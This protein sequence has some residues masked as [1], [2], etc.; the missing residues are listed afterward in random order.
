MD[1]DWLAAIVERMR[2][3]GREAL[4]EPEG[5]QILEAL[6]IATPK[7]VLVESAPQA[8]EIDLSRFPGDRVVVKAVSAGLTHKSEAG[9][10][11]VT[12]KDRRLISDAIRAMTGRLGDLDLRGYLV[13]EFVAYDPAPGGE[14]LL[15]AR[16]T[17]DFGPVVTCGPGGI[18]AELLSDS[19]KPDAGL[20]IASPF[21]LD[22]GAAAEILKDITVARL[23]TE[24]LR[25]QP[26][27]LELASLVDMI[28]KFADFARAAIPLWL[29]EF[30]L[31]PV[32]VRNGEL[33]ALDV[34]G[35]AG[36][37]VK[38]PPAGRPLHKLDMLF[39]PSAIAILG[40]SARL[41]PGHVILNNII[42]DGFDRGHIFVVKPG[43]ETIEGCRCV[44]D[45]SSIE[46]TVDLLIL[47]I[48]AA[49]V[50]EV[51]RRVIDSQ[52]AESAI[53]ITG[54][55]E[56]RPEAEAISSEVRSLLDRSRATAWGGPAVVGANSM[57]IRSAPGRY[58]ATFLPEHKLGLSKEQRLP[59]A[60]ISQSG[61][62]QAA[63]MSELGFDVRYAIS[64]GNQTDLTIADYLSHLKDDT[65]VDIFAVYAEGFKPRDG[66]RFLEAAREVVAAGRT[67]ILYRAGRTREGGAAAVTHTAS[68]IGDYRVTRELATHAGVIVCETNDD[69]TDM[70][71]LCSLL[72]S[73]NVGGLAPWRCCQRRIRVRGRG[74]SSE[75]TT[76]ADLQRADR[77]AAVDLAQRDRD[78]RDR[79]GAQSARHH[80]HERRCVIRERGSPRALRRERRRRLR[81]LRAADTGTRHAAFGC[82]SRRFQRSVDR[83]SSGAA[84]PR[85]REGV[86]GF[87]RRRR[88]LRRAGA[89]AAAGRPARVPERRSRRPP[90]QPILPNRATQTL[91]SRQTRPPP[92]PTGCQVTSWPSATR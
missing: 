39:K 22:A 89:A 36:P 27:R 21:Q 26:P 77:A 47:A 32:V 52:K 38:Q 81:R 28:L 7:H 23:L 54:G 64:A 42:R 24:Q 14:L 87:R 73:K 69:F 17:D 80:P 8:A 90:V 19:L 92:R 1:L 6:G 45:I 55:L 40:V 56:E 61:A 10:V 62:Y 78:R 58:D 74:R 65:E 71:K 50:P 18:Y 30:E 68:I 20:A 34:L 59:I 46:G 13:A 2:A 60:L 3:E 75:R 33:V 43:S 4:L 79:R 63:R 37:E 83:R 9:G 86:G 84:Q 16:W 44:A 5:L 51:L 12:S 70:L 11:A 25:G 67:V 41:N 48:E 66:L 49:Q 29:S 15:G 31:N 76:S 85:N 57:G 88:T 53:L 91:S 82:D 35:R 72:R